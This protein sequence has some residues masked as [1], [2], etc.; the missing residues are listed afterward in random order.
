MRREGK[1]LKKMYLQKIKTMKTEMFDGKLKRKQQPFPCYADKWFS[2]CVKVK[3]N[4][5]FFKDHVQQEHVVVMYRE[6]SALQST[7]Y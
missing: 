3:L 5:M 4:L 2:V 1:K 7:L 6:I